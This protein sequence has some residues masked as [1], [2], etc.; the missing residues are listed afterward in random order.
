MNIA[1]SNCGALHWMSKKLSGSSRLH[2][3]FGTCCFNGK[4]Q[5][6]R[7][8]DPPPEILDLFRDQD[9]I[10]KNFRNHIR[11]YDNALAMTSLGCQQDHSINR[12]GSG[13]YLF[14]VQGSLYHQTG[15]FIPEE[16]MAP[17]YAQIY[18]YDQQKAI[19]FRMNHRANAGLHK[20]TMQI[21]QNVLYYPHPAVQLYRQAF[22][23]TKNMPANQQCKIAL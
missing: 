22:E 13:P 3:K 14:K 8:H 6:P 21:L 23:L 10:S 18:I 15:P 5:I 19:D 9:D 20:E 2:P 12:A 1:C 7:L 16:G 11:N 17:N 4:V